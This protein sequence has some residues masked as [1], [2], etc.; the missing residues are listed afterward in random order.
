MSKIPKYKELNPDL[1]ID[2]IF[3]ELLHEGY[4]VTQEHI[5]LILDLEIEYLALNGYFGPIEIENPML[6]EDDEDE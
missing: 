6:F 2:Y 5:A 4:V 1:L 3:G